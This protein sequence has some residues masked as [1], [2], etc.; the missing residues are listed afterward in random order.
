MFWNKFLEEALC[1]KVSSFPFSYFFSF[2]DFN[3]LLFIFLDRSFLT[4]SCEIMRGKL[5]RWRPKLMLR[6]CLM[7]L[8]S[9]RDALSSRVSML[10][11]VMKQRVGT[12]TTR[13]SN[14]S[15][16]PVLMINVIFEKTKAIVE[17]R[18]T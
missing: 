2:T 5:A 16:F 13:K 12:D 17:I 7:C 18:I 14:I 4:F 10:R 6:T 8:V 11:D 1:S 3:F 9:S 15:F